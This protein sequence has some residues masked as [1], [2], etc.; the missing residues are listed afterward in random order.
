MIIG[1]SGKIGNGKDTV[2]EIIKYLIYCN[3]N[4][5]NN[6][7]NYPVEDWLKELNNK[8]I[9]NEYPLKTKT[10]WEVKKFADKLKDIVCLLIGCT[11][12]DLENHEFKN[13]ELGEE[14]IR[15]AYAIGFGTRD[16]ERI[17]WSNTCSK[18][19]YEEEHRINWQTAYKTT[20]TPRLLLQLLGTECGRNTIHPNI[21]VNSL[22]SEYKP[23]YINVK[24]GK[25]TLI[26][27]YTYY[28]S[29]LDKN[30]PE[31]IEKYPNWIITDLRFPNELKAIEDRKGITIRVERYSDIVI[32]KGMENEELVKFDINNPKHLDLYKAD[33]SRQHES[34]TAL[35]YAKFSYVINNDGTIED[36]VEKVREILIKENII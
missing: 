31:I 21:W 32:N 29:G 18:E 35:D 34:E 27:N 1:I 3:E 9:N 22:F 10:N 7:F 16:G 13:S 36:L 19:K 28:K 4:Q 26:G 2:G 17:M 24:S 14:W 12:E 33:V 11:R 6:W 5:N 8:S 15:Y 30:A 23:K 20:L 25:E